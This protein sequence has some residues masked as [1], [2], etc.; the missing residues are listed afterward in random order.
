[1]KRIR[2]A[3]AS[4]AVIAL[5]VPVVLAGELDK[6][7]WMAGSWASDSAGVRI[8]EHWAAPL[9]G[10]MI[11]MHRD[12]SNGREA[13]FEFLRI[14]ESDS[15]IV[16]LASP[17]GRP[18]TPFK[19]ETL[20]ERSVVFENPAHDFPARIRYWLDETGSLQARVEG[21]IGG[22]T[23]SEAWRWSRTTLTGTKTRS[24]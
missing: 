16:Y 18:A 15:G 3:F 11:G 21:T 24:R 10:A 22:R 2:I 5:A 13:S 14:V 4:A 6:L 23:Q 8:E 7:G 12:V 9:G 1:M 17:N 19:L 20:G